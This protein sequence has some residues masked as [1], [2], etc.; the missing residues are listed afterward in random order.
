MAEL[1]IFLNK[2]EFWQNGRNS[3]THV[4]LRFDRFTRVDWLLLETPVNFRARL[5]IG[6]HLNN[7]FD[8]DG[9]HNLFTIIREQEEASTC[10]VAVSPSSQ[11]LVVNFCSNTGA[12]AG[13]GFGGVGGGSFFATT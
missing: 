9:N 2:T 8:V 13:R 11:V 12:R 4:F 5:T 6:H 1:N 3:E 10:R 7:S